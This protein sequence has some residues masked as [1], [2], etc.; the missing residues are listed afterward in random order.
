MNFYGSLEV[1]ILK[2]FVS[3]L[4]EILSSGSSH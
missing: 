4:E 1:I 2:G 3:L